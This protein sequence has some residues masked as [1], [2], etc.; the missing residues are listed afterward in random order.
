[1]LFSGMCSQL[2]YLHMLDRWLQ[3]NVD[4]QKEL[5]KKGKKKYDIMAEFCEILFNLMST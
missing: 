5:L 4:I 1:M 2:N 3:F